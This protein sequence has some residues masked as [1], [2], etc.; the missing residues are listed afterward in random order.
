VLLRLA[1]NLV[2]KSNNNA[3]VTVMHLSP[4]EELTHANIDEYEHDIFK[5]VVDESGKLNQKITTLFKVTNDVISG[6]TEEANK[7]NYDLLLVGIGQSIFE[8]SLL[9]RILG[10][11]S[12][13]VIPDRLINTVTGK[14]KLFEKSPFEESTRLI[15]ARCE[16]PVGILLT[17]SF[18]STNRV[19]L[20]LFDARDIFLMKYAQKL[21]TNSDSKITVLEIGSR[22][23]NSDTAELQE[24]VRQNTPDIIN[25]LKQPEI[26]KDNLQQQDL[27]IISLESWKKSIEQQTAWLA[28]VTSVLIISE[29]HI[30]K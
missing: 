15:L 26:G 22:I 18:I 17:K 13:I 12:K 16:I 6:I 23:N 14:E 7:G 20:P 28:N 24:L 29:S 9:G 4:N 8:G 2:K 3:A 1:N 27:I 30:S 11:T 21:I 5:P 19:I 10:F 25:H